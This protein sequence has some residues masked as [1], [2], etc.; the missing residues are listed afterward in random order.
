MGGLTCESTVYGK[1]PKGVFY[2]SF[3]SRY[4][5]T[6]YLEITRFYRTFLVDLGPEVY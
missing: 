3:I 6:S 4:L 5:C 2:N 1:R